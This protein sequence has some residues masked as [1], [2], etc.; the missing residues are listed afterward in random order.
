[1]TKY[2]LA[3][4]LLSMFIFTNPV[5]ARGWEK[6]GEQSVDDKTDRD[7]IRVGLSK[8]TFRWLKIRV[9]R[10]AVEFDRV[11]IVYAGGERQEV[12]MRR[13]IRAGDE[14]RP[15]RLERAPRLIRSVVFYYRTA[16]EGQKGRVILYAR[17]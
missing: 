5:L 16:R 14:T 12:P 11:I 10:K 4:A 15:I 3:L 9:E 1:M 2:P 7:E 6:L 8:G 17:D 13:Y